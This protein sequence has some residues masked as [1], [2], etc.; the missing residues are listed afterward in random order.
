MKKGGMIQMI[1]KI[2]I[3]ISLLSMV[4]CSSNTA[5][6]RIEEIQNSITIS[7]DYIETSVFKF[8]PGDV[9]LYD[10]VVS[11]IKQEI[12]DCKELGGL[13]DSKYV[14]LTYTEAEKE[15]KDTVAEANKP[16]VEI[17]E[18]VIGENEYNSEEFQL[19]LKNQSG[20]D[21]RYVKIDIFKKDSF[22]NIIDSVWTNWSGTFKDGATQVVTKLVRDYDSS[23]TYSASISEVN[24]KY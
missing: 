10:A 11:S 13:C 12:S 3:L 6:R 15:Y 8:R 19:T 21:I 22:G 4:G 2:L 7:E 24:Y 20:R 14:N 1:K 17:L 5:E 9:E 23:Y 16:P 18:F